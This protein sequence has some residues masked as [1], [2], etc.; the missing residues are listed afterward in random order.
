MNPKVI[1]SPIAFTGTV[2]VAEHF[3]RT[4]QCGRS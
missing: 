4:I 1:P 3:N 2:V